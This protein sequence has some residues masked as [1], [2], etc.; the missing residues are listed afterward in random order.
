LGLPLL[1]Q[2]ARDTGGRLE[3]ESE[4]GQGT[5]VRA[6]FQAS[7]PD[8]KPLGDIAET[9]RTILAGR[10]ELHLQF[11]YRKDSQVVAEFSS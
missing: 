10:P 11:E 7:H 1:A 6:V 8:R 3:L 9:L 2:A 4:P 5:R